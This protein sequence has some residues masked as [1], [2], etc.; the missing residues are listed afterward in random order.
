MQS[1][2]VR[3]AMSSVDADAEDAVFPNASHR[4]SATSRRSSLQ[5]TLRG[6]LHHAV[7]SAGTTLARRPAWEERFFVITQNEALGVKASLWYYASEMDAEDDADP[8][9]TVE[10]SSAAVEMSPTTFPGESGDVGECAHYEERQMSSRNMLKRTVKAPT[11]YM[12]RI[13]T[14]SDG[15]AG[16]VQTHI[17]CANDATMAELW[18]SALQAIA[19][20]NVARDRL[21][22]KISIL[23]FA[24]EES[25]VFYTIQT[26]FGGKVF[27][28]NQ[29][30]SAFVTLRSA[31]AK[32]LKYLAP[33]LPFAPSKLRKEPE[34]R[35]QHLALFLHQLVFRVTMLARKKESPVKKG[36]TSPRGLW[37]TI[38]L[39]DSQANEDAE[40]H[41]GDFF[42]GGSDTLLQFLG[43][44][45][46]NM[47]EIAAQ[48]NNG[49]NEESGSDV[50]DGESDSGTVPV[51]KHARRFDSSLARGEGGEANAETD[52]N[53]DIDSETQLKSRHKS[54]RQMHLVYL[55]SYR[56][57]LRPKIFLMTLSKMR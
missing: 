44:F 57:R 30:F 40:E 29:R 18:S 45:P 52:A 14:N 54:L 47:K 43:I 4:K 9:G 31:L 22:P 3:I 55:R 50:D 49:E 53:V 32:D 48:V 37:D 39:G 26:A 33:C 34:K 35:K 13:I 7:A 27:E 56:H 38:I 36:P 15:E 41:V 17:M 24:Q 11:P 5:G 46:E 2:Y 20:L 1:K 6:K 19:G 23:D 25:T 16:E 12:F 8:L 28:S 10:L 21:I 42:C 51:R